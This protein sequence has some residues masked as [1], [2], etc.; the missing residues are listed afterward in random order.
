MNLCVPFIIVISLLWWFGEGVQ[1][2]LF[3]ASVCVEF[4]SSFSF[5]LLFLVLGDL[6]CLDDQEPADHFWSC[7]VFYEFQKYS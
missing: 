2:G 4:H 1:D 3:E 7:C 6:P 5:L